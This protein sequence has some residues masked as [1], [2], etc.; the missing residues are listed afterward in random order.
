MSSEISSTFINAFVLLLR[1][2]PKP[3]PPRRVQT[4]TKLLLQVIPLIIITL[5]QPATSNPGLRRLDKALS[6]IIIIS[7]CILITKTTLCTTISPRKQI[8]ILPSRSRIMPPLTPPSSQTPPA[9]AIL[10]RI[11]RARII[12]LS[13]THDLILL[14][15]PLWM[16]MTSSLRQNLKWQ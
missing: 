7:L 14:H 12:I 9:M 4:P 1:L 11:P 8:E 6:I 2:P 13:Q 10:G 16:T 5:L 15:L 3:A